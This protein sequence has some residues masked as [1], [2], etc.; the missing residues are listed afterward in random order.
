[1]KVITKSFLSLTEEER[2][3]LNT[4]A[5]LLGRIAKADI[6]QDIAD[7]LLGYCEI[8]CFDELSDLIYKIANSAENE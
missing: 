2:M 6:N 4:A 3:I 7:L 5:A 1:M 8:G